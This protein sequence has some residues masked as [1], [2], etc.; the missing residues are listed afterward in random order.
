MT[1]VVNTNPAAEAYSIATTISGTECRHIP[2]DK[3]GYFS[4]TDNSILTTDHKL[5]VSLTFYDNNTDNFSFHYNSTSGDYTQVNFSKNGTNSWVTVTLALT[6]AAFKQAQNNGADFRI[7][8]GN[9]IRQ[10]SIEKGSLDP[11]SEP[12]PTTSASAYSEFMGKAVTG[13]QVWFKTGDTSSG[14]SH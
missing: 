4:T 6:D 12:I 10:I 3:Y 7:Y 8:G 13:Y 2:K 1:F 9:Y 14:W 11:T 5:L